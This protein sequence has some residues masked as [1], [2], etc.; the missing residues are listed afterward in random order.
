M[1]ETIKQILTYKNLGMILFDS[2]FTVVETNPVAESIIKAISIPSPQKDL[3]EAFPEFIGSEQ[4]IRD[5]AEKR[6]VDFR[7]DYV[8]RSDAGGQL[9]FLHLLVLSDEEPGRGLLIIEDVTARA[10]MLQELNQQR[11]ELLLYK[12]SA[13]FRKQFLSK[14]ILGES[15]SIQEV[16]H[17]IQKISKIP[18]TTV[19]LLGE[20]GTGKNL[21][22]R[23]IHYSSMPADAPFVDINCAA[24]PKNLIE[25]ELFGYEK[26]AFTHATASRPGLLE[27]A[28]GGTIFLDEIGELPLGLQTK[29]LSV[30]ENKRFRRLGGNKPVKVDLRI[31][32]ATNRD[33]SK[34]VARKKFRE[35]LFYRLNVVALTLP[36]LRK[37]GKDILMMAD[38]FLKIY[39]MEFKKRA[40][41]FTEPAKKKLL[42]YSWPGNVREL[43]NCLERAM[44]FLE[45]EWI[46]ASDLV[47]S[48][49]E[50]TRHPREW[51]IPAEGISLEDVERRLIVSALEQA[52]GN[53]SEAARLLGLTRDTLRYRLEKHQLR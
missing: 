6:A 3:M 42:E 1:N 8:N 2:N 21:A 23:V 9:H 43:S 11:Y 24:L 53:K 46:D 36:P 38:H 37:L 7:L 30:L 26:G 15:P 45:N 29:L 20:T 48:N 10:M 25:S 13:A 51:T 47:I 4:R 32:A 33:L 44:I 39:N 17:T 18:N 14:S 52:A 50:L 5:I 22:A 34:A 35:D 31:I 16:R 12:S 27:E 41:G 28:Q 40:R 19:L 49:K